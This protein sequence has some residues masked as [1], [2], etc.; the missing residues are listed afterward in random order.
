MRARFGP[1]LAT[2]LALAAL[3]GCGGTGR[4]EVE[5][6]VSYDGQPIKAGSIAFLPAGGPGPK[7]GGAIVEGKYHVPAEFGPQAGPH[8][9]EIRWAKPTGKKYKSETGN[10]LEVTQEGLPAKYHNQTELTADLKSGRN[11][12]NF[13]LKK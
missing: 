10:L 2:V 1:A 8:R 12:V 13:Y 5:G 4:V 11:T 6:A 3:P 9:V 7:A